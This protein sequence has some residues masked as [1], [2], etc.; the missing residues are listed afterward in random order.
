MR[1]GD[2]LVELIRNSLSTNAYFGK[3]GYQAK[4]KPVCLIIDELD[5]AFGGGGYQNEGIK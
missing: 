1:S 3:G 4:A 2:Q 5:G